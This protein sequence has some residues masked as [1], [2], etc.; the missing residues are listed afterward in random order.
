M[1][2]RL[3]CPELERLQRRY[4]QAPS[5]AGPEI[6]KGVERGLAIAQEEVRNRAPSWLRP[7]IVQR[8]EEVAGPNIRGALQVLPLPGKPRALP[9]WAEEGTRPHVIRAVRG[10]AL[11]FEGRGGTVLR[12]SVR[13]PGTKAHWYLRDG[14]AAAEPRVRRALAAANGNITRRIGRG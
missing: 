12:R 6:R 11:R 13:H 1:R 14:M 4:E 5:I 10:K 3:R 8:F 9:R 7:Q 2:G